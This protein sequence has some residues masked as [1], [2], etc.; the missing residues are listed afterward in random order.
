MFSSSLSDRHPPVIGVTAAQT[1]T[2]NGL[3]VTVILQS[4]CL[5]L[6]EAGAAPVLIPSVLEETAWSAVYTRL[7][8]ILLSGGGDIALP[9][10]GDE[11]QPLIYETD[12][13]RDALEITFCRAALQ[14]QKPL[15]GICRGAQLLNVCRGGTLYADLETQ[16]AGAI[17]HNY[18]VP[19]WPADYPA[20]S[21]E[22]AD[23]SR[24]TQ[25]LGERRFTVNSRHHQG[26]RDVGDG[27]RPCAWAPDGLVEALEVEGHPFGLAVQWHPE[28][29]SAQPAGRR[30]FRAFVRAC[31]AYAAGQGDLE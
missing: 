29:L 5:A 12:A 6:L 26:I 3:P 13:R 27:L 4:Y 24:L 28:S 31:A 14:D 23:D 16:R 25:V 8:G 21:V 22:V 7:D 9:C 18:P 30:L 17:R 11:P 1:Q 10:Y 15:L 2:Q 20:H 19:T